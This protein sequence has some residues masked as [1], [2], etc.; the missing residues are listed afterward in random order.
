LKPVQPKLVPN[1]RIEPALTLNAPLRADSLVADGSIGDG[2]YGPA[3]DVTFVTAGNPGRMWA[4]SKARVKDPDDLSYRLSAAHTETSLFLALEV[5]DQTVDLEQ[6][7]NGTPRSRDT[8][9][10]FINGDRVANDLIPTDRHGSREG[11]QLRATASGEQSQSARNFTIE[12]W[13]VA[14]RSVPGGYVVEFEIP[15][16]LIDT[17]DG[18]GEVP[19]KTGDLL[20][21]NAFVTDNDRGESNV[22]L[23]WSDDPTFSPY[24]GG[25][26][27]W[28]VGLNLTSAERASVS[29]DTSEPGS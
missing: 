8:V 13:K 20:L 25:E 24:L 19:A 29:A 7:A 6:T 26:G 22:G 21:I 1:E 9:D 18:P 11:F 17:K 15:L 16:R 12:D 10:V 5:R 4:V 14:T 23:L 27:V 3:L 28:T 2:E